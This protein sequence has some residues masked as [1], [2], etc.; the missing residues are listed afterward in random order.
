MR[1]QSAYTLIELV[2]AMLMAMVVLTALIR[3]FWFAR[4]TELDVRSSY[5]IR[6]DAD[7]VFRRL[8]DDLRL[9]HLA[10]IKIADHE[11]GFS[12]ISPL[13]DSDLK[14]FEVTD[15]AVARWKSWVHYT[16]VPTGAEVG[17]LVRW[18]LPCPAETL[19]APPSTSQPDRPGKNQ[20]VVL[21]GVTLPDVDI[22]PPSGAG[23]P[24]TIGVKPGSKQ[25]GAQLRFLRTESG[26]EVL[27]TTNPADASDEDQPGWSKGTTGLVDCRLRVAD[28][29]DE[30]G[31]WSVF[32]LKFR[33]RPRN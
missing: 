30:S 3:V 14:S 32:E 26:K 5:L 17:D 4:T 20:Q 33:V 31:R 19:A 28:Q 12:M 2:I 18:E 22:F 21:K 16:I 15:T 10:S 9:T 27:S 25:S 8:Q 11:R 6:Q 1:T 13:L 29:S 24:T 23:Q 7:V